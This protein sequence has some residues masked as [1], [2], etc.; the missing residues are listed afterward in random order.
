M[1]VK[2][3]QLIWGVPVSID[4]SQDEETISEEEKLRYVDKRKL[5]HPARA[6]IYDEVKGNPH[7]VSRMLLEVLEILDDIE[8]AARNG[9]IDRVIEIK[10]KAAKKLAL[11]ETGHALAL[12]QFALQSINRSR[13]ASGARTAAGA[14]TKK[15][16][17]ASANKLL[18]GGT[19]KLR[20]VSL[21][22]ERL[23][24]SSQHIRSVLQE[25]GILQKRKTNDLK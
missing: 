20:L 19:S 16:I 24:L 5:K 10:E 21:L 13:K 3:Q 9:E 4:T 23:G 22:H 14:P 2:R 11:I 6:G 15:K 17:L 18:N 1:R 8:V 25:E 12:R 7:I